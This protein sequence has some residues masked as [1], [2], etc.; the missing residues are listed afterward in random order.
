[1][2]RMQQGGFLQGR[3]VFIS[4]TAPLISEGGASEHARDVSLPNSHEP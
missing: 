1:M 4:L 2:G 3:M